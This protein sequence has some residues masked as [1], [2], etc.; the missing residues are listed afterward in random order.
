M[1]TIKAKE[2]RGMS[3]NER[4]KKINELKMQLIKSKGNTGKKGEDARE[5]RKIIARI[6]TINAFD[7]EALK[8]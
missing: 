2:I 1:A 4:E 5:I 6:H 3:K 8:K 7:K